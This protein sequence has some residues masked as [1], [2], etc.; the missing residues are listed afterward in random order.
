MYTYVC[1][2]KYWP[3]HAVVHIAGGYVGTGYGPIPRSYT[4]SMPRLVY[5]YIPTNLS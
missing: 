3:M 2:Y 5:M 4:I 1:N